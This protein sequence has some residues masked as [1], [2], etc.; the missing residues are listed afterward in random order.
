MKLSSTMAL[1]NFLKVAIQLAPDCFLLFQLFWF[2]NMLKSQGF[3]YSEN[4]RLW[5]CGNT[6]SALSSRDTQS[7]SHPVNFIYLLTSSR[8]VNI[9]LDLYAYNLPKDSAQYFAWSEFVYHWVYFPCVC[10]VWLR[11][12]FFSWYSI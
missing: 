9:S 11:C 1:N 5:D 6:S 8:A 12:L 3:Q 4:P 2:M 10:L 7:V